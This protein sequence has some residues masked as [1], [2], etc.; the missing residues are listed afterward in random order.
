M[1]ISLY[2]CARFS[3]KVSAA[4]FGEAPAPSTSAGKLFAPP[5]L[6]YFWFFFFC[7]FV[8]PSKQQ[9]DASRE[10]VSNCFGPICCVSV[11]CVILREI[12]ESS[13]TCKMR[14]CAEREQNQRWFWKMLRGKATSTLTALFPYSSWKPERREQIFSEPVFILC[15]SSDSKKTQKPPQNECT[16]FIANKWKDNSKSRCREI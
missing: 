3:L 7:Y 4:P 5:H 10:K 6:F 14:R 11:K 9:D 1:C 2:C 8:N 13:V 16:D 15:I 12:F